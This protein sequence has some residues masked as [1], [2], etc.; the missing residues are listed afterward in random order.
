MTPFG[1]SVARELR[2]A[3]APLETVSIVDH[4][5]LDATVR[6]LVKNALFYVVAT[7]A[8]EAARER[9]AAQA[10]ALAESIHADGARAHG[11]SLAIDQARA[12]AVLAMQELADAVADAEPTLTARCLGIA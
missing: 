3:I 2:V 6:A 9:A 7:P 8:I 10:R 1:Q 12:E 4:R 11:I 5:H